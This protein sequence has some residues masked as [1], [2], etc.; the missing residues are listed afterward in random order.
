MIP[1]VAPY[2]NWSGDETTT[3]FD[4]DFYIE[5]GSQLLV[6]HTDEYGNVTTLQNGVDYTIN[7]VGNINGSYITF[8]KTGSAHGVLGLNEVIS[9]SLQLPISQEAEYGT[10]GDLDLDSLEYSLDYLTRLIQIKSREIERCVK[11][12]EGSSL[13]PDELVSN[14][15][16]AESAAKGYANAAATSATLASESAQTASDKASIATEKATQTQNLYNSAVSSITLARNDA[17]SSITSTGTSSV[18]SVTQARNEAL[19]T[20]SG[21]RTSA[22]N[23]IDNA[24]NG[25]VS[26]VSAAATEQTGYSISSIKAAATAAQTSVVNEATTAM[27]TQKE[28]DITSIAAA[29]SD[30]LSTM[31]SALASGTSAAITS[32]NAAGTS[33]ISNATSTISVATTATLADIS[34]AKDAALAALDTSGDNIIV[35]AAGYAELARQYSETAQSSAYWGNIT[36]SINSQTDLKGVLDTKGDG[37][38]YEDGLLYLT[39]GGQIVSEGIQ[40]AGGGGGGGGYAT[41]ITLTNLLEDD[42][43]YVASGESVLLRYSYLDSDDLDGTVQYKVNNVVK[44]TGRIHSGDAVSFD[45]SPYLDEGYNYIQ[46]RVTDLN[47]ASRSLIYVVNTISLS[48]TSTFD[49]SNAYNS[50]ITF[51]Y[52]PTGDV[53]KTIHFEVDGTELPTE[54]VETSGRQQSKILTFTH[55]VH[56]LRVWAT[57]TLQGV[58][59]SSN[60]LSYEVMYISGS[61]ILIA[62]DF[63]TVNYTEGETINIPMIVYNPNALTTEVNVYMNNVLVSTMNVGRTKFTWSRTATE[64]GNVAIRFEAGNATRTFNIVVAESEMDVEAVTENLELYLTANGRSNNDVNKTSWTSGNVSCTLT[65]FNYV[66][67]G[68][69]NNALKLSNGASVIIPLQIFVND[70]RTNGKTI[71]IE[72]STSNVLSYN[73]ILASCMSGDRGFQITPQTAV[74]KSEQSEVDVK[75]KEDE[76]IRLGFV[77]EPR[78]A[79][80]LI[81]TYLNGII[82]G[83]SQ[84]PDDDDFSQITPVNITLGSS[85]CDIDIYN[86]RVYDTALT[87]YDMLN[88]YIADI[89]DLSQ[90]LAVFTANNIHDNY[91]NILYNKLINQIPIMTITGDL[92]SAK[93]DKKKVTV[94]YENQADSTKN[95]IMNEVT[96]DVQGTSS[97]FYPKKNYKISKLPTAYSLRTNSPAEK[98]FTLKADYMESSHAHNTGLARLVNECYS[99]LTPPQEENENIRTTIDGFPIAIFYKANENSTPSYFG[100]YNFNN[101]KSSNNVFGFTEGCESW[102]FCNNTSDRC[103][104]KSDDFSVDSDV[105]TDFEARYPDGNIDFRNLKDLILWVYDCYQDRATTGIQTFKDECEDYFNLDFLLTYYIISEFFGMVDSRAK[106]MF[107]N[108]YTDGLWYPVFYDLDTAIGL[109]NEGVNDFNFDIETHDS[110]GTQNVFNGEG[111]ALWYLVEQAYADELEEKYNA[112]R[113]SGKLTY[114]KAMQYL[115]EDQIAK[116]CEAQYNADAEFKYISPLV[117]D[118]IATYLYTA[119]GSR[120]DHIKWWLYNRFNYMDSKYTASDFKSNYLTMRL[121]TPSSWQDVE[122][123]ASITVTPYADQYTHIKY[124]S[125]DVYQRSHSGVATTITPP[126]ITFNDTETILYGASRITSI[127]DLSPLYAGTIDVSKATKLTQ[128][129]I[130]AGGNY[131]NTNLKSLTLGN[132]TMLQEL[133][134]RNCPSLTGALDVSGCTNIKKIH[135][136]GTGLSSVKLADAGSITHL[137]LPSTI[138]NLTVKNQNS[139]T[140]FTCGTGITT[141][142]LEN[143][144]LDSLALFNAN[145]VTK[146]RLIGVDWTLQDF[147]VLDT[148]YDLLGS[149]ENGNNTPHGVISGT[150]R[151]SGVKESVANRYKQKFVGI[152]FVITNPAAEDYICTD[153]GEVITTNDGKALLY[154]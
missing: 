43:I 150:I 54:T 152:N 79:N 124:G 65:G 49:S 15:Y 14:L 77:V 126:A 140:N 116:I 10:S 110:I 62:S 68:W 113:N 111:S 136:T 121:Y 78:S 89:T 48:M 144:N 16:T 91:G 6:E 70:F 119:Q 147:T 93:G 34:D 44:H 153:F 87:H 125:Y 112:L 106:N 122:P 95:F 76:H 55:G 131:S 67:N 92:P 148:I 80:R 104:F 108:L 2:N 141:L 38:T 25:G 102:E 61:S 98:V 42:E 88:N 13:T 11:I 1:E 24:R 115:Y 99:T 5:D 132:N 45:I 23:A 123:D 53:T 75:F 74:F 130:G 50:P 96:I 4:F 103:L 20:I 56:T 71:E 36:G 30:A 26:A 58:S 18:S 84:Y 135:A 64:V 90:K 149:D 19:T 7:E 41:S 22:L 17:I 101:D 151:M 59:V 94:E 120:L 127:G 133:D 32:V 52:T 35:E 143:T 146:V 118:G 39:C 9:L 117:D 33:I 57:A 51:R 105:L 114:N 83:I 97:Q 40:V 27:T 145:P 139:I 66:T 129:K 107:L 100:V 85:G 63:N 128:L 60:V 138:T 28:I 8:P 72:F 137:E 109:N 73:T 81:Y 31:T 47:N 69:I 37:L 82:S 12:Q 134:I 46:V 29:A 86:I 142:V 154:T 3:Q 21:A